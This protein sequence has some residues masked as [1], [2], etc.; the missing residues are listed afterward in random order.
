MVVVGW[1]VETQNDGIVK[2]TGFLL[3]SSGMTWKIQAVCEFKADS[4]TPFKRELVDLW[5]DI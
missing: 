1:V 4:A 3:V 2:L 5:N